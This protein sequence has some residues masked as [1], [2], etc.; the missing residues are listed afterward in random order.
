MDIDAFER[1]FVSGLE[2][3]KTFFAIALLLAGQLETFLLFFLLFTVDAL[4]SLASFLL[5]LGH[6]GQ[7]FG[8][9]RSF[10]LLDGR[11]FGL[12]ALFL[13]SLSLFL[14]SRLN[15]SFQLPWMANFI[16]QIS[17]LYDELFSSYLMFK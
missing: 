4:F 11:F 15:N 5:Q 2:G 9:Q 1:G 13:T 6:F 3:R 16:K 17:Y 10:A 7:S 8:F 12:L 14:L